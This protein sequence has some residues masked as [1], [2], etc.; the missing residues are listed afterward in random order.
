MTLSTPP[1]PQDDPDLELFAHT[2]PDH[3]AALHDSGYESC[4]PGMLGKVCGRV[5]FF[6]DISAPRAQVQAW[7]WEVEAERYLGPLVEVSGPLDAASSLARCIVESRLQEN[8]L[9]RDVERYIDPP[10]ERYQALP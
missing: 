2:Y 10:V 4:G 1:A 5:T 8:E 6:L 7:A 3:W 9:T